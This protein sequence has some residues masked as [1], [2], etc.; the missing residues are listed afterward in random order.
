MNH[1]FKKQTIEVMK[2]YLQHLA[3]IERANG[4]QGTDTE[5]AQQIWDDERDFKNCIENIYQDLF[6]SLVD[7][8]D[9]Y[10]KEAYKKLEE[11]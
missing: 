2:T 8:F 10:L 9:D 1:L 5:L 4:K 11:V 3:N 7:N 6:P